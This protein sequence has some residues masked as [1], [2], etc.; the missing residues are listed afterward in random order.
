MAVFRLG[1]SALLPISLSHEAMKFLCLNGYHLS[2][3]LM[4]GRRLDRQSSGS[5]GKEM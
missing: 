5:S 4:P 3:H 2:C 1:K